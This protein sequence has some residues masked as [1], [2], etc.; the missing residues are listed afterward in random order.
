MNAPPLLAQ[1]AAADSLGR[2]AIVAIVVVAVLGVLLAVLRAA[3]ISVPPEFA[4][5]GWIVLLAVVGILAI[6]F[7][8]RFV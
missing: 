1:A 5:I 8:L 7:L 6:A 2:W 3:G 4:R